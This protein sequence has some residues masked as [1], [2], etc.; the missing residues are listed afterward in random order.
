MKNSW[1]FQPTHNLYILI[2]AEIGTLGLA[3]FLAF[4]LF[5]V[6]SNWQSVIGKFSGSLEI[7]TNYQLLISIL[8]FGLFDHFSWDL[9]QGQL[10]LWVILGILMGISAHSSMD[11]VCP[12]EG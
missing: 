8:L 11:R 5:L 7:I 1:E 9:W 6:I 10:M 12:S 3:A 4:V 2:A